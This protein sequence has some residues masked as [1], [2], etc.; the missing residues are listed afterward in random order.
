M[1]VGI[2]PH[3][4]EVG[5]NRPGRVVERRRG[6]RRHAARAVVRLA[7][8]PDVV[9]HDIVGCRKEVHRLVEREIRITVGER[10]LGTRR[11]VVDDL[12]QR[13]ALR[14][15]A[16]ERAGRRRGRKPLEVA[17]RAE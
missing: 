16:G 6:V 7:E 2:V 13:G 14:T 17:V 4:G 3:R 10:K 15:R 9:E 5:A 8:E 11:Q 12:E 1:L